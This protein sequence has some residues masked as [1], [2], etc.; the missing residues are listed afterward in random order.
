LAVLVA[1]A[2]AV[3]VV[4]VVV[5]AYRAAA[6][7]ARQDL[8]DALVAQASGTAARA[9][10][11][12]DLTSRFPRQ[13]DPFAADDLLFQVV[14]GAGTT[15]TPAEQPTLPVAPADLAV[16][17][18]GVGTVVRDVEVDGAPHRQVTVPVAT[19]ATVRRAAV[20]L[21]RPTGPLEAGLADLRRRLVLVGALGVLGAGL[22]GLL[23]ARR[24]LRPVRALTETAEHVASTQELGSR[25]VVDRDD[26]LGRLA[27]S[28][29]AMLAALARSREQQQRLVTDAGHEL[30]TPLT[31][32]RTNVELLARAPDLPAEERRQVVEAAAA[33]V[34]ALSTLVAELVDL[35]TDTR[36]AG[37]EW[38]EVAL[39]EVVA[40][41]VG[42]TRRRH[43]VEV[44]V[45]AEPTTVTGDTAQLDR[46]VTNLL[47]NAVKWSPAGAPLEVEVAG[48][49]VRVL[50]RGP[51]VAEADLGRLW[52]RFWRAPGSRDIPGSGLGL[53]IVAEIVGAHDGEVTA[54][55]RPDG[56]LDIGFRLPVAPRPA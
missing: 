25:I 39:D 37:A 21:A 52:D 28:F 1:G 7:Q 56:G 32:L 13:A 27:E 40:E 9:A 23:V 11:V 6:D 35:A 45:R 17:R 14:T 55:N 51:G 24:A 10:R 42:A 50:D 5:V 46:A 38:V 34:A 49:A 36:R 8:D 16:A 3:A 54:A 47:E 26:E 44:V 41:A 2:V 43:G 29:N 22:L 48:G 53:A 20:Q 18:T 31:S 19:R 30:R 4:V 15:R 33:E 12:V